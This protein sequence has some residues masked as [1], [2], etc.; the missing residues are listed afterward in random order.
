MYQVPLL[1]IVEIVRI[2]V[3]HWQEVGPG[4]LNILHIVLL[5]DRLILADYLKLLDL[6]LVLQAA[7]CEK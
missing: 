6:R 3:V 4:Y 2:S 7:P 5:I 1:R